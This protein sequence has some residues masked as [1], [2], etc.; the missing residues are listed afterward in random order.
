VLQSGKEWK[1]WVLERQVLSLCLLS[2]HEFLVPFWI[3]VSS[4][5]SFLGL[6]EKYL[7]PAFLRLVLRFCLFSLESLFSFMIQACRLLS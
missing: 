1:H 2:S 4:L 5:L 6:W 3:A 7:F